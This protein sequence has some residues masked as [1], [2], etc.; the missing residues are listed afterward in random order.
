MYLE[1]FFG[2]ILRGYFK[3]KL[4]PAYRYY[5]PMVSICL[6]I[7]NYV[8]IHIYNRNLPHWYH[9][10]MVDW[11]APGCAAGFKHAKRPSRH[12]PTLIP[13]IR[14]RRGGGTSLIYPFGK[15][16]KNM[17][18]TMGNGQWWLIYQW[19]MLDN[20][21]FL[22]FIYPLVNVFITYVYINHHVFC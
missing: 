17:N 11:A 7:H 15:H 13:S 8:Y 9:W 6:C 10:L 3:G 21:D 20:G 22:K 12:L 16:G 14:A 2:Y 19:D 5:I 4:V 18:K 1:P